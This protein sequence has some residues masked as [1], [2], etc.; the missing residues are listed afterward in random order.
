MRQEALFEYFDRTTGDA[1]KDF[2]AYVK[3]IGLFGAIERTNEG[4]YT[5]HAVTHMWMAWKKGRS[6]LRKALG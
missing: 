2:E 4:G 1:R 5:N 3:S 6:N